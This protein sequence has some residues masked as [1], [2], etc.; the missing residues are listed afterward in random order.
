MECPIC[1][2]DMEGKCILNCNHSLCKKCLY[3]WLLKE[4]KTCP[5]CRGIIRNFYYKGFLYEMQIKKKKK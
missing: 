5:M 4:K 2:E 1:Y 3:R